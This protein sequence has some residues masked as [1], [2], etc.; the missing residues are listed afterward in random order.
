MKLFLIT[1]SA[2]NDY[3]T[4]DSAVVA[5]GTE[6]EAKYTHPDDYYK[7]VDGEWVFQIKNGKTSRLGQEV[8]NWTNPKNVSVK[9]IG[10]AAEGIKGVVCAS[11]NAG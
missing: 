9:L 1:Q 10:E 11:F 3:D 4:Y 7:W 6:E 2:N 8:L 5:C